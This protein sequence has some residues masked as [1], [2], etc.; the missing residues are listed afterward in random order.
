MVYFLGVLFFRSGPRERQI[1]RLTLFHGY[2]LQ[3][4]G[5]IS[6]VRTELLS[7]LLNQLRDCFCDA[8]K[9]VLRAS[10]IGS[11]KQ[12]PDKIKAGTENSV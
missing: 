10:T 7:R 8:S 9:D 3:G 11:F 2:Q 12:W 5:N 6:A 1:E 4:D